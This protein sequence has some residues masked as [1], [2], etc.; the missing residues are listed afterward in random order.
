MKIFADSANLE[1]LEE[2]A[3]FGV[4]D[5]VTTN[6]SLIAKEGADIHTRIRQICEI[7]DGPVSAE[8]IATAWEP[9]V[10][11]GRE[12]AAIHENVV[13]KVPIGPEGLRAVKKLSEESIRTN[14]TLIFS[15][16]QAIL[17]AK[18]GASFVSPFVGRLDDL[19][20]PGMEM[21]R[22]IVQVFHNY[23]FATQVLVA[24]VRHP[25]HFL[26]ACKMGADVATIP[27]QLIPQLLKHPLTDIGLEK[28]MADWHKASQQA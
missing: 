24:S 10:E 9:M 1:D 25:I 19:A 7:I 23:D 14:V 4:V 13:V 28:F 2:V 20:Q 22:D 21:V 11:E 26:E 6:P 16:T 18:A 8:V 15:P 27:P 17:A 5:G 3:S 12:L